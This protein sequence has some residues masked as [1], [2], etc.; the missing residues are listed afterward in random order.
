MEYLFFKQSAGLL[1]ALTFFSGSFFLFFPNQLG[2]LTVF[3]NKWFSLRKLLK[4][5][6]AIR[7]RDDEIFRVRKTL[8][9]LSLLTSVILFMAISKV[10]QGGLQNT[11]IIF[12]IFTLI[13]ALFL[14]LP[15]GILKHLSAFL[16]KWISLRKLL[17]T[18]EIIR[19]VEDDLYKRRKILGA[20]SFI[21]ALFLFY[22]YIR[23]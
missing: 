20:L 4:P 6:E 5:L 14:F 22:W 19:N 12:S 1:A 3:L 7:Y 8:G 2:R 13:A 11:L 23:L 16:N 10:E 15:L 17:R 21:S 9:G 18:L